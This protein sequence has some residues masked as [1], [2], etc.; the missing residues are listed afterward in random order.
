ML[1]R[2]DTDDG[3]PTSITRRLKT[4]QGILL[5]NQ[6]METLIESQPFR[7]IAEELESFIRQNRVVGY[8]CTKEAEPGFFQESGLR[9][10]NRKQHQS[11]FLARYSYLFSPD[12]LRQNQ[13]SPLRPSSRAVWR[14]RWPRDCLIAL[15]Q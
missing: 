14:L 6:F 8:H 2:I 12:D 1:L 10:L 7:A 11:E 9:V 5:S 3:W 15:Q 13:T 4:H